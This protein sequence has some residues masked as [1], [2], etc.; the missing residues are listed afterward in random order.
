MIIWPWWIIADCGSVA[1]WGGVPRGS[2]APSAQPAPTA[3][4]FFGPSPPQLALKVL[5]K[6][7]G[8]LDLLLELLLRRHHAEL[9]CILLEDALA[10]DLLHDPGAI[11]LVEPEQVEVL[12]DLL[13]A[14]FDVDGVAPAT[15][16]DPGS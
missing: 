7:L 12:L 8:L 15:P 9:F 2:F 10:G 6:L 4:V 13:I 16:A 1:A 5:L 11:L 14:D 3:R